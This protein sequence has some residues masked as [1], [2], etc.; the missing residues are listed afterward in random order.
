MSRLALVVED[1]EAMLTI[2]NRMLT[3]LDYEV[4]TAANGAVAID[5]LATVTPDIMFLDVLMPRVN[6]LQVIEHIANS[7][8][9]YDLRVVIASSNA[10]FQKHAS[11]LPNAEFILKPLRPARIRELAE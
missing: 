6:G 11:D 9:L 10:Q 5:M 1:D 4:M 7:P 2:Y 3:G 8:D